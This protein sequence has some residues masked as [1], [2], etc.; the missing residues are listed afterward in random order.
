VI[1]GQGGEVHGSERKHGPIGG[2][3]AEV[4]RQHNTAQ[5]G[6]RGGTSHTAGRKLPQIVNTQNEHNTVTRTNSK[7]LTEAS[8]E[9]R[10]ECSKVVQKHYSTSRSLYLSQTPQRPV[11]THLFHSQIV[12]VVPLVQWRTYMK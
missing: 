7:K 3:G 6:G 10:C 11:T 12:W 8:L 5:D 1:V 9:P 4:V 2:G